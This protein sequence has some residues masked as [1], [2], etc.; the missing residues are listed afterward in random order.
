[1]FATICKDYCT[2]CLMLGAGIIFAVQFV[3][4]KRIRLKKNPNKKANAKDIKR[5][6]RS[7]ICAM[8]AGLVV[9]VF[10]SCA[11]MEALD[12]IV[13]VG[14]VHSAMV[15]LIPLKSMIKLLKESGGMS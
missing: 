6:I 15:D 14:F 5:E 8:I 13:L 7:S 11:K 4:I 3:N 2:H 9:V 12:F 1:M 10:L